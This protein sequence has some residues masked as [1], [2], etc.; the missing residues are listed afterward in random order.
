M[1]ALLFRLCAAGGVSGDE[2][3]I[4]GVCLEELGR[5]MPCSVDAL[6]NVIG[7]KEGRGINL[8]LDAHIDRIGLVVTAVDDRGFLRV[9]KCGG[10][11]ARVLS[12]AEVTI[13]G[14]EKLFGVVAGIPP[15]LSDESEKNKAADFDS[16]YIDIGLDAE[17]A[18]ALVSPGDRITFNGT[19][20]ALLGGRV[21]SPCID[22]RAG[23]AAILRCLEILE[24]KGKDIC[25]LTVMLSAQEETGGSGAA[26][27]S[28]NSFADEAIAV[29]VGFARAPGVRNEQAG[30]MG[31][32][33]MVGFSPVL[34]RA[35]SC[36]LVSLA[37]KNGIPYQYDAMGG[38]T[39]TNGDDIQV[40]RGG[41]K[42]GLISIPIRNMHTSVETVCLEDIEAVA[43][44]M[45]EYILERSGENA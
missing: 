21:C 36:K 5:F 41:I 34:D 1:S 33:A 28:Y 20:A 18:K 32:G 40:A 42:T 7:K 11:D 9:A 39:G 26:A 2:K 10:A 44:L 30:E 25:T 43:S 23:V 12:S 35:M 14:K 6:G 8:L 38:R 4:A 15:H 24:E 45:A 19:Q 16:T 31:K 22:D 17:K 29:D 13:W 37:Q 3:E 27:G